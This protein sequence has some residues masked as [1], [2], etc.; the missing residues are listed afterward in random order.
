MDPILIFV[1]AA[2]VLTLLGVYGPRWQRA[3]A[4]RR[5][6]ALKG[7]KA[8]AIAALKLDQPA[9]I[10]G[11]VSPRGELITSPISRRPCIGFKVVIEGNEP[12]FTPSNYDVTPEG[13]HLLVQ[14]E[15][16]GVFTLTDGTGTAVIE[17]PYR[18]GLEPVWADLPPSAFARLQ[19]KLGSAGPGD[20]LRYTRLRF[21]EALLMPGDRVSVGGRP[22]MEADRAARASYRERP[23]VNHIRGTA[24]EPVLIID[25]E[26]SV[27]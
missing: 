25:E 12:V 23:M 15:A 13:R 14:R 5:E 26:N 17:G 18:L 19:E 24:Q 27:T 9:K 21:Q 10:T 3:Y 16:C 7:M 6:R 22:V 8:T 11:V 20:A 2:A 1:P 4:R